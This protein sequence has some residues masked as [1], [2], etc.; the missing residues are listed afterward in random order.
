MLLIF[1]EAIKGEE[2]EAEEEQE[3]SVENEDE[4]QKSE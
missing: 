2:Q 3:E 4:H 1:Y